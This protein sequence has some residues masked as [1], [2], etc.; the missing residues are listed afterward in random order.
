M[1]F[2]DGTDALGQED[3]IWRSLGKSLGEVSINM[4]KASND[5]EGSEVHTDNKQ[6]QMESRERSLLKDGSLSVTHF[7]N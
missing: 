1:R 7:N 6:H 2:A 5:G 3:M 4:Y